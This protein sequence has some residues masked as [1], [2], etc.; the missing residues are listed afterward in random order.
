MCAVC[1]KPIGPKRYSIIVVDDK[2]M[3]EKE[4]F[5]CDK[6]AWEFTPAKREEKKE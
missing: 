6:C 1:G 2:M 5:V 4:W 3:L